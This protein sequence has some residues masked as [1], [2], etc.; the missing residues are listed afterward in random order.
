MTKA[1]Q[2]TEA[3]RPIAEEGNPYAEL[4]LVR[5]LMSEDPDATVEQILKEWGVLFRYVASVF[6]GLKEF[7]D[8]WQKADGVFEWDNVDEWA[9]Q[10]KEALNDQPPTDSP[11]AAVTDDGSTGSGSSH[12]RIEDHGGSPS[13]YLFPRTRPS[14]ELGE[15]PPVG[16]GQAVDA[17]N[18][19]HSAANYHDH[20]FACLGPFNHS[21][22]CPTTA[23]G[24]TSPRPR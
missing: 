15:D 17:N 14:D 4:A 3:L 5:I 20:H 7:V 16:Q 13:Q 21:G 18:D 6:R 8:E 10:A 19:D 12:G 23:R 24:D 11:G 22:D 1:D 9:N 2:M